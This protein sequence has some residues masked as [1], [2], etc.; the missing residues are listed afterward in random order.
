[1]AKNEDGKAGQEVAV[2]ARQYQVVQHIQPLLDTAR[3]EQMQRAATALMHSSLLPESVRGKDP[4]ECFSNL[5]VIFDY[6]ERWDVPAVMLAQCVSIVHNKLMFEGKAIAAALETTLG[7]KLD[8]EWKGDVG[9]DGYS[10]RVW[11]VRP[12]ETEPREITGTVGD[13]KTFEKDRRTVNPAWRGAASKMQLAY[14]GAREWARLWAPGTML[15]VYGDDEFDAFESRR[16]QPRVASS[17]VSSGFAAPK[18]APEEPEEDGEVQ[19]AEVEDVAGEAQGSP[20]T[21]EEDSGPKDTG[22]SGEGP[23]APAEAQ[24]DGKA[25]EVAD[26][27]AATAYE[28]GHAWGLEDKP[29]QELL[30]AHNPDDHDSLIE[31]FH[32]GA[33][34]RAQ[35]DADEGDDP[36]ADDGDGD[37]PGELDGPTQAQLRE[38]AENFVEDMGG[39]RDTDP[40]PDPFDAFQAGVRELNS[41][42]E[43]KAS[44]NA[45]TKTEAWKAALKARGAPLIRQARISAWLRVEELKAKGK[46]A[47]DMVTDLTAFRCW[48]ETTEDPDAIMGNWRVLITEPVYEALGDEPKAKLQQATMARVKVLQDAA[49]K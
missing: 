12:G 13:W 21:G 40:E 10:I 33:A 41:W 3:F 44:F 43:V 15:G 8:Y 34:E 17:P 49:S 5:L 20:Q 6:A 29:L 25:Q 42:G 9:T 14:R 32:A 37:P 23:D 24:G 38:A 39:E 35:D 19:D 31:G 2:Q 48:I 1:M 16:A 45:L 30:D 47:I 36:D 4:R 22:Q 27:R 7:V 11:G 18:A 28:T 26:E 46:E